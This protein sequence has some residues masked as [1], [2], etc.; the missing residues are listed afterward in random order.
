M[1]DRNSPVRSQG[2]ME[3]AVV[4]LREGV[5][6]VG[7]EEATRVTSEGAVTSYIHAGGRSGAWSRWIGESDFVAA[8]R[9]LQGSGGRQG[10][11]PDLADLS[12]CS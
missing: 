8:H 1:M 7:G 12:N 9:R 11:Y 3:Q 2:D 5:S 10:L 4:I 6:S